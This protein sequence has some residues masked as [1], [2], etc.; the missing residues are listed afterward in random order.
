VT[1]SAFVL[2]LVDQEFMLAVTE[3]RLDVFR[4]FRVL[5]LRVLQRNRVHFLDTVESIARIR[6]IVGF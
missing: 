6:I 2:G 1:L 5:M 3:A 4:R